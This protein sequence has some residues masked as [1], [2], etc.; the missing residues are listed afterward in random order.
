MERENSAV[1][2]PPYV[3]SRIKGMGEEQRSHEVSG[4]YVCY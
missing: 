4:A 1:F 2:L 3:A